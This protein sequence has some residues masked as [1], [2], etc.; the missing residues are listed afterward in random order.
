MREN[1]GVVAPM[2]RANVTTTINAKPRDLRSRRK[3]MRMS[4]R[5]WGIV[6]PIISVASLMVFSIGSS[7]D[8]EV[9]N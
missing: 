8:G 4:R 6:S 1:T 9:T 3:V 7:V 2:P 5:S